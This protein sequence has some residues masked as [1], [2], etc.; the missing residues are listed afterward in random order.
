MGGVVVDD[1]VNVQ[2]GQG[3]AVDPVEET[4]ELLVAVALHAVADDLAIEQVERREQ[5]GRAVALV[6]V[7]HGAG[8]ALLHGQARLAAVEC[9]D[10]ALLVDRKDHRLVRRIEVEADHVLDFLRERRVVGDLEAVHQ[11]RP[12]ARQIFWTLVWLMPTARAIERTLQWVAS[13]GVS[14]I[15]LVSTSVLMAAL[16]GGVPGGRLLSRN[17]PSTPASR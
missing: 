6:V 15:V 1:Q 7:G 17:R 3:L 9:L 2:I 4:N 14:R 12:C 13:G 16:N 8:P 11:T 5:G 10:L